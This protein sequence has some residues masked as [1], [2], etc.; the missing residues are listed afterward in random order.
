MA[1]EAALSRAMEAGIPIHN[2]SYYGQITLQ[3]VEDIF[4]SETHVPIPLLEQRLNC[5]H[6]VASILN[7]VIHT[8]PSYSGN[9]SIRI[10]LN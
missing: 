2:P 7:A 6:E 8:K 10:P 5:L 1:L 3:E 9:L 4:K